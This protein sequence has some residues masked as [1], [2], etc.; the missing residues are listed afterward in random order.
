M[1]TFQLGGFC[2]NDAVKIIKDK[3]KMK[4]LQA[5]HGGYSADM[6]SVCETVT[7]ISISQIS[8]ILA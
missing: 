6:E 1:Y 7:Y 3:S 8:C 2:E 5:G 4:K